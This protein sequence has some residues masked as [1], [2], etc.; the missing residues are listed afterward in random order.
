MLGSHSGIHTSSPLLSSPLQL[1][2]QHFLNFLCVNLSCPSL[3]A[4][5]KGV[6]IICAN[7]RL[8]LQSP[9][10]FPLSL[11]LSVPLYLTH[12]LPPSFLLSVS[13]SQAEVLRVLWFVAEMKMGNF[14]E[15]PRLVLTHAVPLRR[16]LS[17][18]LFLPS[19][20]SLSLFPSH[21]LFPS[22]TNSL[23]LV[24]VCLSVLSASLLLPPPPLPSAGE[25][26]SFVP[27]SIPL[28]RSPVSRGKAA[29]LVLFVWLFWCLLLVTV[30]R[31]ISTSKPV[32]VPETQQFIYN[33]FFVRHLSVKPILCLRSPNSTETDRQTGSLL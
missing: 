10:L 12:T 33:A 24:L 13:S 20:P 5:Y 4:S 8:Q 15:N 17:A 22:R 18:P 29:A 1:T 14:K 26:H 6:V 25:C 30:G 11:S 2:P 23:F 19:F 31:R 3:Y 9:W 21:S 32:S 27:P 7:W 28:A 16:C